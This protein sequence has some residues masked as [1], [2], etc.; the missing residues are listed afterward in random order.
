[1]QMNAKKHNL[2]ILVGK[3]STS[4]FET[5]AEFKREE[6]IQLSW[7]KNQIIDVVVQEINKVNLK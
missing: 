4:V 3:N 2:S 1:M 7:G 6:K 5:N